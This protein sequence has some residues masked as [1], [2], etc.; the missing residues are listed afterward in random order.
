[1]KEFTF[2][3][4]KDDG[5]FAMRIM[6]SNASDL[7]GLFLIFSILFIYSCSFS[8]G[9]VFNLPNKVTEIISEVWKNYKNN[10]NN[11]LLDR[12]M[13][14]PSSSTSSSSTATS[15]A[16]SPISTPINPNTGQAGTLNKNSSGSQPHSPCHKKPFLKKLLFFKQL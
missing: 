9:F 14:S 3:Y 12:A 2:N 7:I 5:I 10:I 16:S 4:L 6:A 1:M 11:D 15:Q 8:F 13:L